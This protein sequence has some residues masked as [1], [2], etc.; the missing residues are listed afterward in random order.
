MDVV[1]NETSATNDLAN[2][3]SRQRRG[4]RRKTHERAHLEDTVRL[5]RVDADLGKVARARE[6]APVLHISRTCPEG[7]VDRLERGERRGLKALRD[8]DLLEDLP[9]DSKV[10]RQRFAVC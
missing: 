7:G 9:E 3:A 8:V 4:K 1:P 10:V 6:V 2:L 5:N